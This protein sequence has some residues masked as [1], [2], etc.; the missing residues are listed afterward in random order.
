MATIVLIHG[1]A[2]EQL[3]SNTLEAAWLPALSDGIRA[4]GYPEVADQVWPT[5]RSTA[6]TARMAYY[7]DLFLE[8]GTMGVGDWA[9]PPGPEREIAEQLAAEWL[10]RGAGRDNPDRR[11]AA[12]QL[13]YLN[14]IGHDEQGPIREAQRS[15]LNGLAKL[16]WFAPFGMAF[17]GR[18]VNRALRQVTSYLT[19][20]DIR[21]EVQRRVRALI[22]VN[23][24]V[25]VGHSLGSV[26]AYEA[27][28]RLDDPVPR[29]VTLG[30]P[31]GLRTIVYDLVLPQPPGFPPTVRRWVNVAD[32]ND[33]VAAEPDLR[34]MFG[35]LP[36]GSVFDGG[37]T[38]HNGAKPHEAKFYL[39]KEQTGR[40]IGEVLPRRPARPA[41]RRCRSARR[42]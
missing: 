8:P 25:I 42:E 36:P 9:P 19:N 17:A 1:I 33:L 30:S 20:D 26:V 34:A 4:G 2:Q 15:A 5:G 22:D 13:S 29:L 14:S 38:V 40:P 37:W 16:K 21:T 12:A 27:A 7:G 24:K 41:G 31:L 32:R 3:G 35:Q 39:T 23:T 10:R 28:H 6:I 11:A 18:F